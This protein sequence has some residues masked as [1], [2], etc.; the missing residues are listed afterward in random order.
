MSI[1]QEIEYLG[2]IINSSTMTVTL[3]IRK[4]IAILKLCDSILNKDCLVI[5]EVASFIGTLVASLPG[6]TYGALYYRFLEKCKLD[7][8]RESRGD[9]DSY[10]SF[11]CCS[12][13]NSMVVSEYS[14]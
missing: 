9:F 11:L 4:K 6:V 5:R 7:A 8:L 13:R 10:D 3:P 14:F 1:R 12:Y 2:F